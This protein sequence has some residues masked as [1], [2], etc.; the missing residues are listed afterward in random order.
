VTNATA[1]A[2]RAPE[3]ATSTNR[4]NPI[5]EMLGTPG[6]AKSR[7]Y[8][9]E[10]MVATKNAP[11]AAPVRDKKLSDRQRARSGASAENIAA[12]GTNI[13]GPREL[14]TATRT[15]AEPVTAPRT[16]ARS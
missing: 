14:N 7:M 11:N 1:A 8:K 5:I 13:R 4:A 16:N 15:R 6:F 10:I 2:R 3:L 9:Y 12:Y